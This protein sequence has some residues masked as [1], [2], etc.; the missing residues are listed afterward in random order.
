[1][2]PTPTVEPAAAS[3]GFS[4]EIL[5]EGHPA[6]DEARATFNALIDRRPLAIARCR[7]TDDVAI[8]TAVA[9][10]HG[11]PVA[12]RG[13]GHNVA[14]HAVCDG[15]LV[16]D[17]TGLGGVEVDADARIARAGGGAGVGVGHEAG[18]PREVG[19]GAGQTPARRHRAQVD[20][21]LDE[22]HV[23]ERVHVVADRARPVV[24]TDGGARHP[25]RLEDPHPQRLLPRAA[26]EALHQLAQ[27]G[28]HDVGVVPV[29]VRPADARDLVE[30]A[31]QGRGV[32]L[33]QRLPDVAQGLAGQ[34]A[35]V[36]EG[37]SDRGTVGHAGEVLVEGVVEVE[38]A[39]VAQRHHQDGGE[40]LGVGGDQELVVRA[41]HAGRAHVGGADA[42]R[43]DRHPAADHR[44]SQAGHATG[45]LPIQGDVAQPSGGG[46]LQRGVH[47][48]DPSDA[49]C[50]Q[51]G[52]L[53]RV[54]LVA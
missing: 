38:P 25:Q 39:L 4:G 2:S 44:R 6:Y 1:V 17:L 31:H 33:D 11:L 7:S 5:A 49:G 41:G 43:P 30:V 8:A 53:P 20:H 40:G 48:T 50:P 21:G 22:G 24:E 42:V 54:G 13:G 36:G 52:E 19:D 46:V 34:S 23:V 16:V 35:R 3:R 45:A 37:L 18:P 29:V 27:H 10:E 26:L 12:V 15:G 28:I 14:G 47:A 9:R 51:P 32:G